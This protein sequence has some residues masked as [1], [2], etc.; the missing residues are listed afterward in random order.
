MVSQE[1]GIGKETTQIVVHIREDHEYVMS[2]GF[3]LF[4]WGLSARDTALDAAHT[5]L[6]DHIEDR[7]DIGVM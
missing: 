7:H 3:L 6:D 4:G 2:V 1:T 5:R